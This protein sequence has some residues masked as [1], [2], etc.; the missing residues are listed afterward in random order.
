MELI[1]SVMLFTVLTGTYFIPALNAKV[2]HHRNS[3]CI[4]LTNLFFGWT[5]IGWLV[6]LIWLASDKPLLPRSPIRVPIPCPS[7]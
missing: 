6:A 5:A 7:S 2:P 1:F 3:D 4:L